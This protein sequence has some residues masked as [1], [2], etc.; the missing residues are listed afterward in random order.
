MSIAVAPERA[1]A[2]FPS[3]SLRLA[4]VASHPVQYQAP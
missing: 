4:I 3:G 2:A 1:F